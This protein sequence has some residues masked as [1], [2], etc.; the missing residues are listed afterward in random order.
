MPI[1][2][3]LSGEPTVSSDDMVIDEMITVSMAG[4]YSHFTLPLSKLWG[5]TIKTLD[6][7]IHRAFL[8]LTP[9]H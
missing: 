9:I 7:K 4:N 5:K 1:V 8:K 6:G 2:L 3:K